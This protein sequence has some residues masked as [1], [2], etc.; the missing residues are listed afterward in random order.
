M[1]PIIGVL[2]VIAIPSFLDEKGKADDVTAEELARAASE[3]AET[4]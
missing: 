4:Y 2:A 3:A 1:T